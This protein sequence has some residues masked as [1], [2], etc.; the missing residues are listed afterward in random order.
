MPSSKMFDMPLVKDG[1]ISGEK[2]YFPFNI[3]FKLY[4]KTEL[5]TRHEV[6]KTTREE[7]MVGMVHLGMEKGH[8]PQEGSDYDFFKK[9]GTKENTVFETSKSSLK[10]SVVAYSSEW[11]QKVI[12]SKEIEETQQDEVKEMEETQQDEVKEMEETQ[13]DEV[14]EMEETQQDEVKEMEE[15]QQDE[16][17]EIEETQQDEVK[18]I[19]ETQQ[20][21]VKE[22][23]ETQQDEVKEMEETQ[24]DEVKE[25]EEVDAMEL[26]ENQLMEDME[27]EIETKSISTQTD[28]TKLRML[29]KSR[30]ADY[31]LNDDTWFSQS[32]MYH[33]YMDL[34]Q[35]NSITHEFFLE[36]MNLLNDRT[37][38]YM[39]KDVD[40]THT[41]DG[42]LL[43]S[44]NW[45][46][47]VIIDGA[48]H[49]SALLVDE[50]Y[51]DV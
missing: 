22:M 21:E 50:E 1:I 6:T 23:E 37:D 31:E 32:T 5:F 15:T 3:M 24:Q 2:T 13:Q 44:K 47:Y 28:C 25:M 39:E 45:I 29:P 11:I 9:K 35:E 48:K 43:F 51:E 46:R 42:E 49:P 19:E 17:K 10:T 4:K 36:G 12:L 41:D 7:F 30:I 26:L 38:Y 34:F 33:Y 16:V 18:E 14:K 8:V 40:Y 27:I 20:D